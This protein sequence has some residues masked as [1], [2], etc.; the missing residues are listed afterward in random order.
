[1]KNYYSIL[2]L[3]PT[4]SD[5]EIKRAYYRLSLQYHPDKNPLFD[6]TQQFQ[7]IAE[8]YHVLHHDSLREQ[9]DHCQQQGEQFDLKV[10]LQLFKSFNPDF[11]EKWLDDL[12]E[13][14]IESFQGKLDHLLN[15]PETKIFQKMIQTLLDKENIT[16]KDIFTSYI[17]PRL[18]D[19]VIN[20]SVSSNEEGSIKKVI[21]RQGE[22]GSCEEHYHQQ[23][24]LLHEHVVLIPIDL[25]DDKKRQQHIIYRQEGDYCNECKEKSDLIIKVTHV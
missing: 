5:K 20:L 7:D 14:W 15:E 16:L 10:A 8:A 17:K 4:A 9:Y 12:P 23:G 13:E 1:M 2:Q 21:V 24:I 25:V 11:Y 3:Q 6:T 22:Y 18:Q 19:I